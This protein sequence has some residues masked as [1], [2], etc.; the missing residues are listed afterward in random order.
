M[1]GSGVGGGAV[2][3]PRAAEATSVKWLRGRRR[4][5][6]S[7]IPSIGD[8]ERMMKEIATEIAQPNNVQ[9]RK[10]GWKL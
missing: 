8:L 10:V 9:D 7:S 2:R 5:R 1:A 4:M 3:S 6:A